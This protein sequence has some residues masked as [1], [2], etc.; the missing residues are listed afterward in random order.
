MATEFPISEL[1]SLA[2]AVGIIGMLF[3]IF[4]FSK[5]EMRNLSI[6]IETKILNDL[7]EKIHAMG[8]M[9]IHRPELVKML[10]K[11]HT[12]HRQ[13]L[14]SHTISCTCVLTHFTC[15]SEMCLAIMNGLDGCNG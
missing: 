11:N 3:V 9:L 10:N 13:G 6:D 12:S 7:D 5:K 15:A 1:I 8:E 14:C 2:E 4:Y